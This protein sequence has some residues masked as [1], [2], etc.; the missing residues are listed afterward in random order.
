[1]TFEI[2][3]SRIHFDKKLILYES[4]LKFYSG[5]INKIIGESG[6]GKSTLI[7]AMTFNNSFARTCFYREE[8]I[9]VNNKDYI[10]K[11]LYLN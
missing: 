10:N 7:N 5:R 3:V 11:F 2:N 9:D 1:M 6:S 4:N 8:K